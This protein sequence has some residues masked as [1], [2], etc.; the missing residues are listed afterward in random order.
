MTQ[1]QKEL[2]W[3]SL[4]FDNMVLERGLLLAPVVIMSYTLK[5]AVVLSF[6]FAVITFITVLISSFVPKAIPYTIRVI[7]NVLLASIVF[8]PVAMLIDQME[9]GLVY[10]LGIYLPLLVTN[11]LIVQ[12]S[13]T[14]FR[15]ALSKGKM[16]LDLLLQIVGFT[17]VSCLVGIIRELLG[18]GTLWGYQ[19][20]VEIAP[21]VLLPFAGFMI[22]AFLS[23]I[24]NRIKQEYHPKKKRRS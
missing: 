17:I 19:I 4:I 7:F 24:V 13:E 11:S 12:K 10:K 3:K 9:T 23:A 14:R 8:I 21:A 22:I 18:R 6:A 1:N 20:G 2:S 16:I 5:N 15:K